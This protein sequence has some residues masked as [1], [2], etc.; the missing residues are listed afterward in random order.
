MINKI[1]FN[2]VNKLINDY[3]L[4]CNKSKKQF[5]NL[6]IKHSKI[7]SNKIQKLIHLYFFNLN[8]NH[9]KLNYF[10]SFQNSFQKNNI[11]FNKIIFQLRK[12]NLIIDN[13]IYPSDVKILS[14]DL[15][16]KPFWN[17]EIRILSKKLFLPSSNNLMQSNYKNKTLDSKSWFEIN[18]ITGFDNY[19]YRLKTKDNDNLIEKITKTRKIKPKD[20]VFSLCSI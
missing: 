13:Y 19:Y 15:T 10:I 14:Q 20:C 17:D 8:I 12:N 2:E 6:T 5:V 9:Y 7:F 3:L 18:K 4:I 11:L 16:I 1:H